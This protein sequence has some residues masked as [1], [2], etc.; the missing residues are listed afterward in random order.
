MIT[1]ANGNIA[2]KVIR[3]RGETKAIGV[4]PEQKLGVGNIGGSKGEP[5]NAEA[6]VV[7]V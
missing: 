6:F 4:L 3:P 5:G 2:A 7:A 1:R